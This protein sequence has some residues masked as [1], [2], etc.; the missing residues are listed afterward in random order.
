VND[1]KVESQKT[2][3]NVAD[4]GLLTGNGAIATQESH[5]GDHSNLEFEALD[6]NWNCAF[7][8]GLRP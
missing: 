3:I 5:N 4:V 7:E 6:D 1:Q 8:K 2:K